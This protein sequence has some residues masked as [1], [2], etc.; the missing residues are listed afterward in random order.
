MSGASA[1]RRQKT[2]FSPLLVTACASAVL[3]AVALVAFFGHWVRAPLGFRPVSA[4]VADAYP[5][6]IGPA[7]ELPFDGVK[8]SEARDL[9][10]RFRQPGQIAKYRVIDELLGDIDVALC[11]VD[12]SV[13]EVTLYASVSTETRITSVRQRPRADWRR[14]CAD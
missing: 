11:G 14:L 3:S 1:C 5:R 4:V 8:E 7:P 6:L 12:G 10:A 2:R 13:F 9:L